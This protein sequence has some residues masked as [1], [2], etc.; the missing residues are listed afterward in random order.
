M[1]K[2]RCVL[3]SFQTVKHSPLPRFDLGASFPSPPLP[4]KAAVGYQERGGEGGCT[5]SQWQGAVDQLRTPHAHLQPPPHPPPRRL[6]VQQQHPGVRKTQ[7]MPPLQPFAALA[8]AK[9]PPSWATK[10][11]P[12]HHQPLQPQFL[13]DSYGWEGQ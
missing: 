3:P 9:R 7:N 4:S 6:H 2:N 5:L 12:D 1:K 13:H 8:Q 11:C 10:R